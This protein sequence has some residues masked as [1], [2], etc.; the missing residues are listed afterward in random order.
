MSTA[1]IPRSFADDCRSTA[2]ELRAALLALYADV[3]ADVRRP[4]LV[5]RRFSLNKN[6]TWKIAKVLQ[7]PDPLETVPLVPGSEG[8][9]ILLGAMMSAG[10]KPAVVGRVRAALADFERMI[11]L[12]VGDRTTLEIL[13]DGLG[14]GKS[15]EMS[16]KL[17]FRGNSGVWGLQARVRTMAAI[18]APNET[19]PEKL[20]LALVAGM[21]DIRRL[22]P[23]QGWPI[24]RFHR[25]IGASSESARARRIEPLEA[26]KSEADPLL[27]MRS[28]CTPPDAEV[29]S[30][31]LGTEVVHEL[32]EGPV[33]RTGEVSLVFGHLER[34]AVPRYGTIPD[35]MGELS[36]LVTIPVETLIQ[37]IALHRDIA[38]HF[39]PEV[40]VY[41]RPFGMLA[42]DPAT[43][44]NY[45]LPIEERLAHLGALPHGFETPHLPRQ[46]ALME[47]V[48]AKGGWNPKDFVAVRLVLQYPPM[49]STA[50]VRYR[51]PTRPASG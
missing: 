49:P 12:H 36:A 39:E 24:F 48:F 4:Q 16:R 29:R 43:R 47:A 44:E 19:D 13:M 10:A 6:L 2:S 45:R 50:L 30:V 5:A 28:W 21:F 51:L 26:P 41:G 32:V 23:V 20:D 1:S 9:G 37:D 38:E 7:S 25:L 17:A 11:A 31:Q 22:R 34:A 40:R 8:M 33:G 18:L 27:I 14:Q 35:E 15:L 46:A 3:G 42:L